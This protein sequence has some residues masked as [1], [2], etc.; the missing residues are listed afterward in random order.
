MKRA[1][2]LIVGVVLAAGA[3][4]AMGACGESDPEAVPGG[5][6]GGGGGGDGRTLGPDG[7]IIEADGSVVP[8]QEAGVLPD[9]APVGEGG[10]TGTSC[11]GLAATCGGANDC[12]AS[13]TVTGGTFNRSNDPSY[14]ATISTFKLDVYEVTVGRF[15]TFVN[16]GRGTQA[17]APAA[18]DGVHPKIAGSGWN[19]S[20]T[21]NLAATTADLK[22]DLKCNPDYPAWTDAPAGNEN[23]PINCVTWY[24]ALAFCAWD[25][26]RLP[27]EAE[28]N[29]AAA[30]G[31]EQR[32]YPWG[33]TIDLTKAS[34]DCAGDGSG[35]GT[36]NCAFS[37]LLPVGSK[38]AGIGKYGQ[39]DL[40]GNA[41]EWTL[42][43]SKTPYRLTACVDCADLQTTPNKT[44]RGG[45]FPNES[46]Y[47]TTAT[48]LEDTPLDRDYDVGF[49]CARD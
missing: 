10:V 7:E 5:E 4:I 33:A 21:A 17:G 32:E 18:G 36:A 22:T 30:G 2:Q 26:G 9:G 38:P 45:G 49:R 11:A 12:C 44:F 24:D 19:A 31:S 13:M 25:G 42:D 20:F 8:E 3:S 28:W 16:A 14:P 34:Y 47:E 39:H 6:D 23:K 43:W 40:A 1:A 29:Y 27:T 37:D 35:T 48:R 15:R 46:F 41:W